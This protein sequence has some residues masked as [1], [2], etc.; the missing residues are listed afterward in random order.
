MTTS[1]ITKQ[2]KGFGECGQVV[3]NVP[4]RQTQDY[5]RTKPNYFFPLLK[6]KKKVKFLKF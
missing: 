6:K 2:E 4:A 5:S 1:V 3:E